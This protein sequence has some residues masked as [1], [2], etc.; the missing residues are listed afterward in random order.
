[1]AKPPSLCALNPL[2]VESS[3]ITQASIRNSSKPIKKSLSPLQIKHVAIKIYYFPATIF[4]AARHPTPLPPHGQPPTKAAQH[5][6]QKRRSPLSGE[7]L[8][9]PTICE[10]DRRRWWWQQKQPN[11]SRISLRL[12]LLMNTGRVR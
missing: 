6:Q 7:R 11:S 3:T 4:Y 12:C 5:H 2:L 10:F 1:M 8:L 9:N